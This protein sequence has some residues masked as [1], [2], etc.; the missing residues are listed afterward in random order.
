MEVASSA[1]K[2][3][4]RVHLE[5]GG[6]APVVVFDDVDIATAVEGIA[7]AGYFNAGQDCTAAT[8]VLAGAGVYNDFVD[9]LAE[10]AKATVIG[11]PDNDDALLGPVNNASQFERVTGFISRTPA[12][13]T[14]AAGGVQVGDDG[15]FIAPTVVA[16]LTRTTR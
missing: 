10:Q 3:L 16:V 6:K 15:F 5:L 2:D 8:R 1:A 4:K 9:A 13:A 14:V 7:I 12:H 11:T